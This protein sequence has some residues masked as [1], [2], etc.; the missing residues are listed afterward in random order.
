[1]FCIRIFFFVLRFKFYFKSLQIVLRIFVC[2]QLSFFLNN[3][4]TNE[5]GVLDTVHFNVQKRGTYYVH[6]HE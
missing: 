1:M 2:K 3:C 6:V 5:V 4:R